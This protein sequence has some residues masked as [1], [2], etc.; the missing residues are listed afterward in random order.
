LTA[1]ELSSLKTD[2]FS[3]KEVEF[4]V[5][6][7]EFSLTDVWVRATLVVEGSGFDESETLTIFL[8]TLDDFLTCVMTLK[9]RFV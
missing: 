9:R 1:K 4:L 3:G 6:E 8:S 7:Q 5:V 2:C